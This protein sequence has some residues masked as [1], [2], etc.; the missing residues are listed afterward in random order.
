MNTGK[1]RKPRGVNVEVSKKAHSILLKDAVS[2]QPRTT[3]R[4]LVNKL[5]GLPLEE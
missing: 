5:L 2:H 1:K 4:G 3:L